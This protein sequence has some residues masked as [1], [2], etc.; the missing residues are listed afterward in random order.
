MQHT[1]VQKFAHYSNIKI[2]IINRNKFNNFSENIRQVQA[3]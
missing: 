1:V 3:R 2:L